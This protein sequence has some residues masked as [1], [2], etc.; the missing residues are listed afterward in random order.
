M[1]GEFAMRKLHMLTGVVAAVGV[2]LALMVGT[3]GARSTDNPVV[4]YQNDGT[5]TA[6]QIR[7]LPFYN[8]YWSQ[9]SSESTNAYRAQR[10]DT[11]GT[12]TYDSPVAGGGWS[13]LFASNAYRRTKQV[14]Q[15]GTS[16][17]WWMQEWAQ[18]NDC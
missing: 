12:L 2:V 16:A 15:A 18:N 9:W 1:K 11:S 7:T 6:G 14:N 8:I 4:C 3:A 13:A 5:Y 17:T 10:E